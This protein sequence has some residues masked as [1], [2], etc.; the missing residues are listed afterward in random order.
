MLAKVTIIWRP[1][2]WKSSFFNMYTGHKIAI[3]WGI[4][5]NPVKESILWKNDLDLEKF[6]EVYSLLKQKY[7]SSEEVD[8]KTLVDWAISGLV[9]AVWDKHSEFLTKDEAE[10][11][12]EV[13]SWDFEGI[14]AVV[15]KVDFWVKIERVLK[16]SIIVLL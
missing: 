2:V 9:K 16:W 8:K 4:E 15:E 10:K 13:L 7:Y 14:W 11:F 12:N 6:W 5:T 3:N 1:N